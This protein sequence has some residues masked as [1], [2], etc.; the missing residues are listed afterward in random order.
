MK[1][2]K[3]P[4]TRTVSITLDKGDFAGWEMTARADFPAKYLAD[5]QSGS[6]DRIIRV[7]DGIVVSHNLPDDNDQVASSMGDVSPY[8]GLLEVAGEVLAAIGNLPNR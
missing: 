4:P 6:V 7:L 2:A 8:A 1:A 5:L 3:R